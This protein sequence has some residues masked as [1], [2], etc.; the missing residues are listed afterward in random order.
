VL[1]Y[2]I[3]D[4]ANPVLATTYNGGPGGRPYQDVKVSGGIGYFEPIAIGA[5]AWASDN[6]VVT[7]L[8]D[9]FEGK[10]ADVRIFDSALSEKEIASLQTCAGVSIA[11]FLI[12]HDGNGINCASETIQ[13][14]ALDGSGNSFSSYSS[15]ITLDT[16]SARGTWLILSGTGS[17]SDATANDGIAQYNFDAADNGQASFALSYL[18][19]AS[20][21]DIDVF[22]TADPTI[23]D[24]DAEGTMVFA[25]SGFTFTAS[26]LPNPPASGFADPISTQT[27]GD[28]FELHMTAFG[29]I[30]DD[31]QCGVIESYAGTRG[32][33]FWVSY[34]DPLTGSIVPSVNGTQIATD[35]STATAQKVAFSAGQASVKVEYKDAGRIRISASDSSSFINVLSGATNPFVVRPANLVISRVAD[36]SGTANPAATS[37]IG[38]GFAAAGTAFVV[39]VEARDSTGSLTPNFGREANPESLQVY[40]DALILPVGGRNGSAGDVLNGQAFAASK[41]PG[42]FTNGTVSFDEVGIIQLRAEVA[43]GDYLSTGTLVGSSSGNVGR[44]FPASYVRIAGSVTPACGNFTYMDQPAF[45][46]TYEIEARTTGGV[47]TLNYDDTL[48]GSAAVATALLVAENSDAGTDLSARLSPATSSW[49]AGVFSVAAPNLQFNRALTPDG[50]FSALQLGTRVFDTLDNIQLATLD[51]RADR[52]GDCSAVPDCT[53]QALGSPSSLVFGRLAVLPGFGPEN[54]ALDVPLEAQWFD[55][56]AFAHFADDQCTNYNAAAATLTGFTDNLASGETAASAPLA[57][58]NLVN[59]ADSLLL[60]LLLSAPGFGN[61]GSLNLTLD[62]PPWMEFDWFGS[63]ATN[64]QGRQTFGR[65][66]GHDRIVYWEER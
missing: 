3:S 53:A 25:P 45:D 36:I 64:P 21:I 20:P 41:I 24:S 13:V 23:R 17:F 47:L 58:T 48:L 65:Y 10:I 59:G 5:N 54:S 8:R 30:A 61:D 46:V 44:F 55:G 32:L 22:E 38:A 34:N 14:T 42:R 4:P 11:S 49:N 12:S 40:S 15:A 60:P 6:L 29:Q 63:G 9:Y 26:A 51:M 56:A 19:G 2:D 27:A 37:M 16:N 28:G 43:D 62:A 33:G 66:R 39:D 52:V 57:S 50:P 7:P 18:E 31:A 1:I 35:S